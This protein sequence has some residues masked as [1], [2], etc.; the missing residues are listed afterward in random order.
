M[1]ILKTAP[2]TKRPDIAYTTIPS[3]L[4]KLRQKVDWNES[5]SLVEEIE[6]KG[7]LSEHCAI[8]YTRRG[9]E[10]AGAVRAAVRSLSLGQN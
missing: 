10:D 8:V 9:E 2:E 6:G 1:K 3:G 4:E 7:F 5:D